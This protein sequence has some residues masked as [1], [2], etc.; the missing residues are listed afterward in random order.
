MTVARNWSDFPDVLN[1]RRFA[2]LR[3]K[4]PACWASL[5]HIVSGTVD[6]VDNRMET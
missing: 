4:D 2:F 5:S 1:S 3:D 6:I